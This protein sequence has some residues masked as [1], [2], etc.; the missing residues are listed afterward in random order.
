MKLSKRKEGRGGH[1][2]GRGGQGS[3]GGGGPRGP[4]HRAGEEGGEKGAQGA[5]TRSSG[6]TKSDPALSH[7]PSQSAQGQTRVTPALP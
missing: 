7:R 4:R 2:P 3:M 5:A 6:V 1:S